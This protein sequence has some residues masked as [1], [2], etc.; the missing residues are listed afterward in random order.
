MQC[1]LR[2]EFQY[3]YLDLQAHQLNRKQHSNLC[4]CMKEITLKRCISMK[5]VIEF[6]SCC[7][8]SYVVK[9]N[10]R[11]TQTNYNQNSIAVHYYNR[12]GSILSFRKLV[13]TANVFSRIYIGWASSI[14]GANLW[15]F[16][17]LAM[18]LKLATAYKAQLHKCLDS[19]EIS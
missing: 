11:S 19:L 7:N 6:V 9:H 4:F 10:R 12:E 14:H 13:L 16:V 15:K 1:P 3:L 8:I 18:E 2:T 17:Y 5:H